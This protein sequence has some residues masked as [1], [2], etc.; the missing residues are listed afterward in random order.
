MAGDRKPPTVSEKVVKV[1]LQ[2]DLL[3]VSGK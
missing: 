3:A 1:P 2:F